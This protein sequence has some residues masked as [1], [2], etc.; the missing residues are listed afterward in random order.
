MGTF[1]MPHLAAGTYS[2]SIDAAGFTPTLQDGIH[3]VGDT[4]T[5]ETIKLGISVNQFIE[6]FASDDG[7]GSTHRPA[8]DSL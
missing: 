1:S 6:V 5:R 4:V 3:V 2:I 8:T 7:R